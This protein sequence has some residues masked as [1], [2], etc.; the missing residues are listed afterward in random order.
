MT[1]T[2]A[3]PQCQ[4]AHDTAGIYLPIGDDFFYC[5][6]GYRI[7]TQDLR[8]AENAVKEKE[9]EIESHY[10]RR[11][12]AIHVTQALTAA[13][14]EDHS[15]STFPEVSWRMMHQESFGRLHL[16][17]YWVNYNEDEPG[18]TVAYWVETILGKRLSEVFLR[19]DEAKIVARQLA[20]EERSS[21]AEK[22]RIFR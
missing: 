11:A 1:I 13:G 2:F 12:T 16:M 9:A 15:G 20:Q 22:I 7:F 10:A 5:A 14:R 4:R 19:V 8:H 21:R 3:C 18:G 6:C 17:T